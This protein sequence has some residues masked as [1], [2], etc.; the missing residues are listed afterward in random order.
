MRFQLIRIRRRNMAD[1]NRENQIVRRE[2]LL[3]R[4]CISMIGPKTI[5]GLRGNDTGTLSY[6]MHSGR[7]GELVQGELQANG[8]SRAVFLTNEQVWSVLATFVFCH[9]FGGKMRDYRI[10]EAFRG[11]GLN[12]FL[13]RIR[14]KKRFFWTS[15]PIF[16]WGGT[17]E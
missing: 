7:L 12:D 13:D 4:A 6:N 11:Q 14:R 5:G 17:R 16:F 15:R 10:Q 8:K 1:Y 9:E 2:F 3:I